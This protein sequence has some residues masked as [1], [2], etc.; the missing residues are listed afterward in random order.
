[1]RTGAVAWITQIRAH[2]GI[3]ANAVFA[4]PTRLELI[5]LAVELQ[6]RWRVMFFSG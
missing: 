1:V 5:S 2:R 4:G 6:Q 3:G